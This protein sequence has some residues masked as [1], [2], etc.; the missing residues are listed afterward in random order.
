MIS[1]NGCLSD[2]CPLL[3]EIFLKGADLTLDKRVI[4]TKKALCNAF[5][6]IRSRKPLEKITVK[7]LCE[8]AEINKST[9]YSYY[10]DVYDLSDKI[11][12][13]IVTSVIRSLDCSYDIFDTPKEFAMSLAIAYASQSTLISNVFSGTRMGRLPERIEAALKDIIFEKHPE[14]RDSLEKNLFITYSVYGGFYVYSQNHNIHIEQCAEFIGNMTEKL[15][16]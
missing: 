4:K 2:C 11:E 9:F 3:S 7:E 6:C 8:M 1:N 15:L 12:S 13:D 5:L 14:F 10:N 16:R